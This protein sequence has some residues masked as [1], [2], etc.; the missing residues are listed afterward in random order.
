MTAW[1]KRIGAGLAGLIGC[2]MAMPAIGQTMTDI[3]FAEGGYLEL[4]GRHYVIDRVQAF[5][6]VLW[7]RTSAGLT[8][9]GTLPPPAAATQMIYASGAKTMEIA[10]Q[11]G[12]LAELQYI[13]GAW[14]AKVRSAGG[15]VVCNGVVAAPVPVIPGAMFGDGFEL[16]G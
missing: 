7:P 12:A 3:E 15:A 8:N 4:D 16:G 1:R 13:G 6:N 10:P 9:C 2:S 5:S 14:T 11:S